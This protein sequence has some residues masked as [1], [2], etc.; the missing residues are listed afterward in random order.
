MAVTSDTFLSSAATGEDWR[1]AVRRVIEDIRPHVEGDHDYTLGFLY[2]TDGLAGEAE[3]ILGLLKDITRIESWAGCTGLGV[4]ASGMEIIDRPG[5]SLMLGKIDPSQF[6]LLPDLKKSPDAFSP[7]DR[8][9][10]PVFTLVHGDFLADEN[11]V[12][13]LAEFQSMSDGFIAGGLSSARDRCVHFAGGFSDE[14]FSGVAFAPGLN[15]MA[16]LTQGCEPLGPSHQITACEDRH[17]VTGLDGRR[18]FDVFVE[19]LKQMAA[20]KT[21][22]D[23]DKIII[24]GS[25]KEPKDLPHEFRHLFRGEVQAAFPVPQTDRQDFMVRNIIGMDPDRGGIAVSQTVEAG[26]RMLFVR[27]D[28]ETVRTDLRR[29]LETQRARAI[30]EKGAFKPAGAIYVS[31]VARAMSDFGHGPGG[32]MKFAAD[33]LGDIPL[34]GFYA[35]GEIFNSNLYGYT[36]ILLLFL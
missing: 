31:C 4:C 21:G 17:V 32:E 20:R 1:E 11:G 29:M 30:Q 6:Q 33:I 24:D 16:G 19:D 15:I 28:D 22:Q 10:R 35:G 13:D 18:P 14:S 3:S 2:L 9:G 7:S 25:L 12:H 23:P 34:T 27:R 8:D 36:G 26:D 5:L